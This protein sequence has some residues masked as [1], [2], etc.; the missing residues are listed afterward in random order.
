MKRKQ[1]ALYLGHGEKSVLALGDS[2]Q[3]NFLPVITNGRDNFQRQGK[4]AMTVFQRHRRR[5]A[6]M[7]GFKERLKFSVQRFLGGDGRLAHADLRVDRG[8]CRRLSICRDREDQN[9]LPPIIERDILPRLKKAQLAHALRRD[10]AGGEI[11][12]TSRLEFQPYVGD[13]HLA[14]KNRQTDCPHLFYRRLGKR[15]NDVEI[16]NHQ[17]EDDVDIKRARREHAEAVYLEEHRLRQQRERRPN[18][19]I[20]ALQMSDLCDTF[21]SGRQLYQLLRL[22]QR[23]GQRLFNQHIDSSLHQLA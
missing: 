13:I 17:V 18:R 14:R 1:T 2:S 12:D 11:R 3:V 19:G 22:R 4:G 16:V 6:M 5:R 23:R 21:V 15:Q 10:A 8:S 9:F 7:H 20:K